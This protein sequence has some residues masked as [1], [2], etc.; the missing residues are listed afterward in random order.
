M[1]THAPVVN[2]S[3]VHWWCGIIIGTWP[4]DFEN[5]PTKWCDTLSHLTDG[6]ISWALTTAKSQTWRPTWAIV[7]TKIV[8]TDIVTYN[9]HTGAEVI[10]AAISGFKAVWSRK[11][12]MSSSADYWFLSCMFIETDSSC[13]CLI[14][15]L[16]PLSE[17][18]IQ[19]AFLACKPIQYRNLPSVHVTLHIFFVCHAL[20]AWTYFNCAENS[21]AHFL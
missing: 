3:K 19:E 1:F 4:R 9:T 2:R 18:G 7:Q 8:T 16:I 17:F 21:F 13:R 14:F 10:I 11:L 20:A 12:C 15:S 5:Q 6:P